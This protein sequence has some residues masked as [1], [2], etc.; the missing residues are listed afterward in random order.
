MFLAYDSY[1]SFVSSDFVLNYYIIYSLTLSSES[2][3][4]RESSSI[5]RLFLLTKLFM[6]LTR[7]PPNLSSFFNVFQLTISLNLLDVILLSLT[8]FSI[9]SLLSLEQFDYVS[10]FLNCD[11]LLLII[12][13]SKGLFI[14]TLFVEYTIGPGVDESS[15][16]WLY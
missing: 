2:D 3:Y 10:L 8:I 9:I 5:T 16:S 7:L 6:M 14:S 15:L 4:F 1:F 11:Q 12:T 13:L